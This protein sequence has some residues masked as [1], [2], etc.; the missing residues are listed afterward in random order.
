MEMID[1]FSKL[2]EEY[3]ALHPNSTNPTQYLYVV[4]MEGLIE[5]LKN[6]NGREIVYAYENGND[7]VDGGYVEYLEN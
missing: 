3:M 4:G 5:I 2:I 6:A 7:V 1:E